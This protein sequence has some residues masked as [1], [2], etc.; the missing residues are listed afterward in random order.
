MNTQKSELK[1]R[2]E[3]KV[4]RTEARIHE[5]KANT[6]KASREQAEKLEHELSEIKSKV[7]H[8]YDDLKDET[9][10]KINSWLSH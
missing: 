5:L 10:N 4:K 2:V 8:G 6:A 9:V 3:A 7:K 1:D